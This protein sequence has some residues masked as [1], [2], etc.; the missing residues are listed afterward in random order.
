MLSRTTSVIQNFSVFLGGKGISKDSKRFITNFSK[1][2]CKTFSQYK[3]AY[4]DTLFAVLF[5]IVVGVNWWGLAQVGTH[6]AWGLR[7]DDGA[8]RKRTRGAARPGPPSGPR[9]SMEDPLR[10]VGVHGDPS[11]DGEWSAAWGP[12]QKLHP[13]W[14][15]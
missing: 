2:F 15:D 4:T 12:V 6:L 3:Q 14:C 8:G 9:V 11:E 1:V 10:K 7:W 5:F 13:G